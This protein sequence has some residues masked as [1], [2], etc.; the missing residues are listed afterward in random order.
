MTTTF[1][2]APLGPTRAY[3]AMSTA[4]RRVVRAILVTCLLALSP[5]VSVAQVQRVKLI[6]PDVEYEDNFGSAVAIDGDWALIGSPL[7]DDLGDQSGAVYVYR[8]VSGTWQLSQKLKASDAVPSA[9]FGNAL[10]MHGDIAVVGAFTDRPM[11]IQAAGSVYVFE[12]SGTSWVQRSKL[13]ASDASPNWNFGEA[14]DISSGVIAV[15]SGVATGVSA[16][17]GLAYVF[18]GSGSSWVQTA[19]LVPSDA[20]QGDAFGDSVSVDGNRLVVGAPS[21]NLPT[22]GNQGVAYYFVSPS[23]GSWIEAQKLSGPGTLNDYLGFDLDL[24]GD[25]LLV[26]APGANVAGSN[27]GA[28]HYFRYQSGAWNHTQVL[29]GRDSTSG[30]EFGAWVAHDDG[31][32]LMSG[33]ACDDL[34]PYSGGGYA[35]SLQGSMWQQ[36]GKLLPQDSFANH[37]VGLGVAVSGRTAI[38]GCPFDNSACPQDPACHSGAA[39]IFDLPTNATQYGSCADNAPCGNTDTHGGCRNKT[40]HGATLQA[41][42]NTSYQADDLFLQMREFPPNS[43]HR[44]YMGPLQMAAPFGNGQRLVAPGSLGY[45]RFPVQ[46]ANAQG[47]SSFGPGIIAHSQGFGG[48]G[49]ILPGQ[50]WCFQGWHRD[51]GGPCGSFFNLTNGLKVTFAP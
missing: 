3:L 39:Y 24:E 7:D 25:N 14:V 35:F 48:L 36:D 19:R 1:L 15:G 20:A 28:V 33:F 44:L 49:Q 4:T 13:W 37:E 30:D 17:S 2:T 42:G 9:Q 34:A 47:Y 27:S 22:G 10:A 31:I 40:G 5:G 23:P 6:P 41:C 8:R 46:Q 12:R 50:T 32:A 43:S 18:E 26:S 11:G 21:A 45:Y 38:L 51:V 29:V 16:Y